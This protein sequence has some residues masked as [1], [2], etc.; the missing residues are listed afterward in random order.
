MG[1]I[2]ANLITSTP[3]ENRVSVEYNFAL[4]ADLVNTLKAD[5][6]CKAAA[7]AGHVFV[8][9]LQEKLA[10]L[11]METTVE[12]GLRDSQMAAIPEEA[13]LAPA[14]PP[15]SVVVQAFA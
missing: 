11:A 8:D 14:A 12:E 5:I 13:E 2:G 1:C 10:K 4:D 7:T 15:A 6:V 9:C 3:H